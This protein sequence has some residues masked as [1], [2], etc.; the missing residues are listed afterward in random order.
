M[1]AAS[2]GL[3]AGAIGM[4]GLGKSL[5]MGKRKM[6]GKNQDGESSGVLNRLQS[7]GLAKFAKFSTKATVG[8]V[9]TT[10]GFIGGTVATYKT[11]GAKGSLKRA[12]KNVIINPTKKLANI[13]KSKSS[14]Q[15]AKGT[16]KHESHNLK[17]QFKKQFKNKPL[18]KEEIDNSIIGSATNK[19]VIHGSTA[20]YK[21]KPHSELEKKNVDKYFENGQPN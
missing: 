13:V 8:S 10:A 11:F 12:G 3:K 21:N 7:G 1:K 14:Q 16:S 9:L 6:L 15:Y 20:R 5:L 18:K 17:Q 19:N 2:S 4:F